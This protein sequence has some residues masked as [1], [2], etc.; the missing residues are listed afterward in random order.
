MNIPENLLYSKTHEWVLLDG[1]K[2][3]IGLTDFAQNAMGDIVYVNLP[4]VGDE[5]TAGGVLGEVE[6]VKAVSE[7][8]APVG[9]D[10]CAVNSALEN[11]PESINA[12]PYD[13]W[14]AEIGNITGAENLL[15]PALYEALC[16]EEAQ[17]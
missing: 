2:A 6:S 9:G 15:A 4:A 10:I 13:A 14:I 16:A 5:M 17:A 11:T 3:R 12:S 8:R 7:V 1:E